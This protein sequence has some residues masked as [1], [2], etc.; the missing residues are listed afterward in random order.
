[1]T[2]T[3]Q[4]TLGTQAIVR[5][6]LFAAIIAALGLLPKFDM[7]F[8]PVTA[9]TLGVM[10]AGIMLGARQGALAVVLFLF[11]VALG[12]P[13]LAGG[14]GG[15]TAFQTASVGYLFGF[16]PGAFVCGYVFRRLSGANVFVSALIAAVI[17][18]ILVIH[19]CGVPVL[20]WKAGLTLKQALLADLIFLPGDLIKAFASGMIALAVH[21]AM[22]SLLPRRA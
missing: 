17:G 18:G 9:Q 1:M 5:I 19:A 11:V 6:A 8:V 4:D 3:S 2:D 16:I 10:L 12:A 22:P 20:A 21:R 14:R 13:F 7:P 15:L